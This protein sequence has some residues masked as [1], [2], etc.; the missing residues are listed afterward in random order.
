MGRR[1]LLIGL[2]VS[3]AVNLFVIGAVVGAFVLGPR[4]HMV[5][6]GGPPFWTAAAELPPERRAA[7]RR[8][9][10]GDADEVRE[11]MRD[12]RRARREAWRS[13]GDA[14]FTPEAA[15]ARLDKARALEMQAR[16]TIE[17]RIVDFAVTLSPGERALL[18]E[19]LAKS[20][21]RLRHEGR[22]PPE[23]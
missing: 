13:V 16:S 23:R 2:I 6:R 10:R 4:L 3:L 22:P 18:A 7:Y 1:G 9:L 19:G 5:T 21:P 8:A 15:T 11:A 17:R 14:E 12:A 20:G